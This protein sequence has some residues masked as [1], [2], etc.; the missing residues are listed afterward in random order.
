MQMLRTKLFSIIF[1]ELQITSFIWPRNN[2]P[3]SWQQLSFV[4]FRFKVSMKLI[5]SRAKFFVKL[6]NLFIISAVVRQLRRP[7]SLSFLVQKKPQNIDNMN[8]IN[9]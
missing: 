6:A 2:K 4:W 1:C 9:M 8:V 3:T 7:D 5:V